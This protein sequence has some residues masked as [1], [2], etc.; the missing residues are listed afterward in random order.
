[1]I[2]FFRNSELALLP[3]AE[4]LIGRATVPVDFRHNAKAKRIILRLAPSKNIDKP[5]GVVVTLPN[6]VHWEE[7]LRFAQ[8]NRDW[9]SARF[10]TLP[11]K[12]Y[13]TDGATIPFVGVDHHIRH[14][15]GA[16]RGV[17]C[18]DNEIRVSGPLSHLPRRT[19]DWL[20]KE[21]RRKISLLIRKIAPIRGLIPGR[22]TVRDTRSRWGSCAANG[23]LSF[24]WRL[25][26]A[27]ENIIE[28]VVA[29]EVAHLAEHNH[30]RQ[31]WA[32]VDALT[33]HCKVGRKWLK[34]N[35]EKLH[36]YG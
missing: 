22:I 15:P 25:V 7:G 33:P 17:W 30:S 11:D 2:S 32:V 23:N 13:F 5:D 36:R 18:E 20:K 4:L 10:L 31:F 3:T 26:L 28:Y 12:I 24:S 14:V 21:S 6:G 16:R 35:G 27:P 9:I 34:A 8:T 29:H 19:K 1:V